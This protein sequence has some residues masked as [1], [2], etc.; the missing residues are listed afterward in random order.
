[1]TPKATLEEIESHFAAIR[2]ELRALAQSTVHPKGTD[3]RSAFDAVRQH[4]FAV[5]LGLAPM[6]DGSASES[7][8]ALAGAL[9]LFLLEPRAGMTRD[10][11]NEETWK[12][13]RDSFIELAGHLQKLGVK[14][15]LVQGNIC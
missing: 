14:P 4:A 10:E 11:A 3:A 8:R 6:L 15:W 1:M 5:C 7:A 9:S 2:V 13:V 12:V